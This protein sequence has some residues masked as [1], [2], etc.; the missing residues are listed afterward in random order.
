M[1][2]YVMMPNK[3]YRHAQPNQYAVAPYGTLCFVS[4]PFESKDLEWRT[5][6]AEVYKQIS[7]DE[8]RPLWVL[9]MSESEQGE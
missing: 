5:V 2:D 7:K 4:K 1:G 8:D 9:S 6:E 3:I